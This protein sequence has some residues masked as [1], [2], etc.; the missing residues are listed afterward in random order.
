[1][2]T[3]QLIWYGSSLGER[4]TG[5]KNLYSMSNGSTKYYVKIYVNI[6]E[7]KV[8]EKVVLHYVKLTNP[9]SFQTKF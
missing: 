4:L 9:L 3:V 8:F 1:M 7:K 6:F 2:Q 5:Y